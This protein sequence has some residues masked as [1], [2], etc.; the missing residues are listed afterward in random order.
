[1]TTLRPAT[2]ADIPDII[3]LV[4]GLAEYEKLLHKATATEADYRALMFGPTPR[5]HAI[6]AE[7]PG[8]APVGIAL[9]YYTVSTFAGHA[10][11]FLEDL[12]V[13]PSH[14]GT[15]LGLSLL[16]HLAAKAITENCG[17]VDWRVLNWNTLAIKFYDNIGARPL[18]E[19][20]G[21]CLDGDALAALAKG[22]SHG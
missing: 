8:Q 5:A 1:M 16:Q 21:R 3:R 18:H 4:R 22:N 11:I 12:Y 19:W 15:G 20:H 9:Y 14:R 10:C 13:E 6:L 2:E 17:S 7:P